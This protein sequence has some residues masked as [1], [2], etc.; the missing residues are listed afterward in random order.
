MVQ[1]VRF[2]LTGPHNNLQRHETPRATPKTPDRVA[3]AGR[4]PDVFRQGGW[5]AMRESESEAVD[6]VAIARVLAAR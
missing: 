5:V 2:E 6:F 1:H 4:A 3:A